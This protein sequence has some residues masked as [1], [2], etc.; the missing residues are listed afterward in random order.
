MPRIGV[1]SF[2]HYHANF[3]SEVFA[4]RGVH[5]GIWDDDVARG[6]DAATRF[7]CAFEPDLDALL[8]RCTAVAV[9]SETARHPELIARA[10]VRGLDVLVEKPLAVSVAE[11]ERIAAIVA[12]HPVRLMQ[13]FP[14]RFDPVSRYLKT[15]VDDGSL[16]TVSLV[17]IR[18]GHYY[19]FA[20]D[21]KDRWYVKPALCGGGALIDEGIHGADLL[22][23]LFGMPASVSAMTSSSAF[24]LDVED[25]AVATYR[26]D[27]GML[28]ELTASF[29]FAAADVSIEIY[30][31]AG[32]VLVSGVDLASRDITAGGFV[33]IFRQQGAIEVGN[34]N[35]PRQWETVDLTPRFKLGAFHQQNA[36]AFLDCLQ[37]GAQPPVG[38]ADGLKAL[39]MIEAAYRAAAS[40]RQQDV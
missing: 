9:C 23:W 10:A 13:S 35:Q 33:R 20:P 39:R 6:E 32:T 36:L 4:S 30:G 11:G 8:A 19:G 38:I 27:S 37:T 29:G 24:G 21:F 5:A 3:W 17:R 22:C 2:A 40:G 12:A 25:L 7:D 34:P 31:S 14:K 26:F 16:G 18:H 28:A 15:L 1:L